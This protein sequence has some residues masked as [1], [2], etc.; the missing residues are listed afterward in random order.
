MTNY[1]DFN[2]ILLRNGDTD[3]YDHNSLVSGMIHQYLAKARTTGDNGEIRFNI[4]FDEEQ[5]RNLGDLLFDQVNYHLNK[6]HFKLSDEDI[7]SLKNKK[8]ANGNSYLETVAKIFMPGTS[9]KGFKQALKDEDKIKYEI[10]AGIGAQVISI[11]DKV[12]VF[13]ALQ[14]KFDKI[15]AEENARDLIEAMKELNDKYHL[16]AE[17][18]FKGLIDFKKPEQ[19]IDLYYQLIV[20][21]RK[22]EEE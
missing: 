6:R 5:K 8:D 19:L 17:K 20:E 3:R 13:D 12:T 7:T 15:D 18:K 1:K 2:E 21:A 10:V 11:Y 22:K 14:K 9:A 16:V 4:E